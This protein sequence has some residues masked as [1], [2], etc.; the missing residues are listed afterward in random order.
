M[1]FFKQIANGFHKPQVDYSTFDMGHEHK[2]TMR[3]GSLTPVF[4]QEVLPGDKWHINPSA[5]VRTMPLVSPM[6]HKVDLKIRF[7]FVPNRLVWKNWERFISGGR[8]PKTGGELFVPTFN[9]PQATG[10]SPDGDPLS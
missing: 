5:F 2:T 8:D 6:M 9:L 7:F 10:G 1:D 4:L 3:F